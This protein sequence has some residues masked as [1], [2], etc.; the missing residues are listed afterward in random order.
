[1]RVLLNALRLGLVAFACVLS[2]CSNDEND[3]NDDPPESSL[4]CTSDSDCE[5][6]GGDS[7]CKGGRCGSLG[8]ECAESAGVDPADAPQGEPGSTNAAVLIEWLG[9]VNH[10]AYG[11]C[12][13]MQAC[14]DSRGGPSCSEP[15][16]ELIRGTC[17]AKAVTTLLERREV[18]SAC[19]ATPACSDLTWDSHCPALADVTFERFCTE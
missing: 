6:F 9:T 7:R 8:I 3:E 17:C 13:A 15:L 2:S 5:K 14:G 16:E 4:A 1:M 18:L 10:I 11:Y 19:P 12:L